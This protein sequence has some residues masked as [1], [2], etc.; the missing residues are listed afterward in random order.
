MVCKTLYQK[1]RA[2]LFIDKWTLPFLFCLPLQKPLS[3]L[4]HTGKMDSAVFSLLFSDSFRPCLFCPACNLQFL[5]SEFSLTRK[6][7]YDT[8]KIEIDYFGRGVSKENGR[9]IP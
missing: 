5:K 9:I 8:L 3:I 2:H 6:C 4:R 7:E 1:G